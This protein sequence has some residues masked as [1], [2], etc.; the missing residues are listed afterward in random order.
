MKK[1]N[2]T[3]AKRAAK[4]K[5]SSTKE[6]AQ[7]AKAQPKAAK[8]DSNSAEPRET[9][10]DRLRRVGF[11]PGRSGNPGGMP[12]GMGEGKKLARQY[13][14]KAILTL[15]EIMGDEAAPRAA[16][17]SAAT[18]LLDR[19]Y[20][21]PTQQIEVGKPGDFSDMTE[22][23]IDAFIGRATSELAHLHV[24]N[25]ESQHAGSMH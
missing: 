15:V 19:G 2:E 8:V 23:Q 24:G 12:K 4:P 21:K 11:Q 3:K 6:K 22:D 25:P 20:G 13:T 16:R 14:E 10:A 5:T 17:V 18:A 1:A 7:K 9:N